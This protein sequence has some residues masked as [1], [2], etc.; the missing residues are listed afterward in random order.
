MNA[1]CPR[2]LRITDSGRPDSS[3]TRRSATASRYSTRSPLAALVA[4]VALLS[5]ARV[6][7]RQAAIVVGLAPVF[8]IWLALRTSPWL[9]AF[10]V[11]A[12]GGL[13]VTGAALGSRS[14]WDMTMP[15]ALER[16][17]LTLLH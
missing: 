14:V 16:A 17:W 15:A 10:D 5:T 2:W 1:S 11:V 6:E 7:S 3:G 12:A 13:L 9:L 8:A 4:A